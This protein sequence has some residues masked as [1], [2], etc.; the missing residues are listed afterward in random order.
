M[1]V[2]QASIATSLVG[3]QWRLSF[4]CSFVPSTATAPR[5]E[6]AHGMRQLQHLDACDRGLVESLKMVGDH[7]SSEPS[8]HFGR[9]GPRRLVRL[10]V[11]RTGR[12]H[13]VR[14]I[15]ITICRT[16]YGEMP[17]VTRRASSVAARCNSLNRQW[18]GGSALTW[19]SGLHAKVVQNL[20]WRAE[21]VTQTLGIHTRA[22]ARRTQPAHRA[23]RPAAIP[24][25]SRGERPA[26]PPAAPLAPMRSR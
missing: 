9:G 5:P 4:A 13:R 8:D 15:D 26:A 7:S 16:S 10:P 12:P 2:P 22:N 3:A 23:P 24:R 20:G 14:R 25:G 6:H 11:N 1:Q 21:F 19:S 17:L 18:S